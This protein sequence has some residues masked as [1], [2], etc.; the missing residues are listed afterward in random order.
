M[1]GDM[2]GDGVVDL[3]KCVYASNPQVP[4]L[5]IEA[6]KDKSIEGKIGKLMDEVMSRMLKEK[7]PDPKEYEL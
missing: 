3:F 1:V 4:A 6:N 5:L 7:E 2:D